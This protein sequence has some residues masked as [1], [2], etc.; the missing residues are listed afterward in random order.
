MVEDS[1]FAQ[2]AA[3]MNAVSYLL[4]TKD[5]TQVNPPGLPHL[6]FVHRLTVLQV[7]VMSRHACVMTWSEINAIDQV[8]NIP[9]KTLFSVIIPQV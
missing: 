3:S 9:P 7:S 2:F 4:C 8:Y 6:S 1:G 5:A